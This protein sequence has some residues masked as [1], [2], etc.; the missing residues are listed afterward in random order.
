MDKPD[1]KQWLAR[2]IW[3]L[4]EF[5]LLATGFEPNLSEGDALVIHERDDETQEWVQFLF[6][7]CRE[8]RSRA[9]RSIAAGKLKVE[10]LGR[11]IDA[12]EPIVFIEWAIRTREKIPSEMYQFAKDLKRLPQTNS[13]SGQ[14]SRQEIRKAATMAKH[15]MWKAKFHSLREKNP[16]KS[17]SWISIQI[18]KMDIA[19]GASSETIRKVMIK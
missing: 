12:A 15:D 19:A 6:A 5:V 14:I 8:M 16:D 2:D 9:E 1:Y 18:S 13:S 7:P 17:K 11:A 3:D 10:D 4:G